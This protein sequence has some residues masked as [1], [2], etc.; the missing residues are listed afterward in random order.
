VTERWAGDDGLLD[1]LRDALRE[2]RAVPPGF[3]RAG[4]D[5][6]VLRDL[7]I[8]LAALLHD[9]AAYP[10]PAL[11]SIR[12]YDVERATV[13]D[14]TFASPSLVISIQLPRRGLHGQVARVG[15]RRPTGSTF[16]G[17]T[18]TVCP[19]SGDPVV[20]T[21]DKVGWFTLPSIP[22]GPIRLLCRTPTGLAAV[23]GWIS[24]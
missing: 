11:A 20:A 10:H 12:S 3:V 19:E 2:A 14:V 23:T 22:T 21:V 17:A 13:R 18:V 1:A 4:Q 15:N 7:D 9:S 5:L 8:E 6:F 16:D 24:I